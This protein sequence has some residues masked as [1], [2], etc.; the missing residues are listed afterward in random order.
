MQDRGGER[1]E[2]AESGAL[3]DRRQQRQTAK[4]QKHPRQQL[5]PLHEG[6]GLHRPA[7][8]TGQGQ[9]PRAL[10][11]LRQFHPGLTHLAPQLF[12]R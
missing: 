3:H 1:A 12:H 10:P 9:D 11:S 2:P 8:F 6:P 4:T 7:L 5:R